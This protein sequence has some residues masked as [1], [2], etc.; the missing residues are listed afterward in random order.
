MFG[1][2]VIC[3]LFLGGAGGGVCVVVSLLGLL[4]PRSLVSGMTLVAYRRINI[5]SYAAAVVML[6][7]GS[8]CLV[9]DGV[10]TQ[11]L[12]HLF[13]SIRLT[14]LNV[15]AYSLVFCIAVCFLLAGV[16]CRLRIDVMLLRVM[17]VS[18]LA[19]GFVV[20]LYTGLLLSSTRAVPLWHTPWLLALFFFSALSCGIVV[21]LVVLY[22][23]GL[24][25]Q[26]LRQVRRLV[27]V[28]IIIIVVL[29]VFATVVFVLSPLLYAADGPTE[30]SA[31]QSAWE[32][33]AGVDA[34]VFWVG[35]AGAGL[36]GA[37]AAECLMLK[38]GASPSP[39]L[40]LLPAGCTLMGAFAM[41]ACIVMAGGHPVV[42]W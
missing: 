37:L 20:I 18:A 23:T 15:G 13:F 14:Y 2:P 24:A 42:F 40:P 29:E 31:A 5:A 12:V 41:R 8:L 3:Y 11:A 26:F 1:L 10:R 4:T 7:L 16:W 38:E 27:V 34:W 33:V 32:L 35:F 22:M 39:Y 28:D 21:V 30:A 17:Q 9:S 25:P 36:F 19:V 6:T